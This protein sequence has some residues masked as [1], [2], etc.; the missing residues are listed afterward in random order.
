GYEVTWTVG[1]RGVHD[2]GFLTTTIDADESL[3][4]EERFDAR[5]AL[6]QQAIDDQRGLLSETLGVEP[7]AAPQIFV[8]YKEVLPLY[9]PG[10]RVPDDVTLVW[11]ND[12]FGYIRRFPTATELRRSGGHGLYYHSSYWSS[13]TTSYLATSSTPLA[14]M[15]AEL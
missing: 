15:K 10:L 3:T 13:P 4:E 6:L 5:V 8:P 11:A 14:L 12:N 2:T 7:H 9:D 1:M